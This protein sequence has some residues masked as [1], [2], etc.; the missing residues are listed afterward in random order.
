[1][2]KEFVYK[3]KKRLNSRQIRKEY[4]GRGISVASFVSLKN[5]ELD[6]Y[7]NF[8]HHCEIS[9]SKIGKRTSVGRYTK[10]Q[11]A[12]IGKYCS[13]SWD[14]TIGALSHPLNAIST[15][16]FSYRKQFGLCPKDYYLTHM[17]T[18]IG[19]DVWIGCGSIIMPGVVIGDGAVIGA[20]SVVLHDVKPY[21]VVAGIPAKHI[22][23]RFSEDVIKT[24]LD[25]KWWDFDDSIIIQKI[26]LFSPLIDITQDNEIIKELLNIKRQNEKQ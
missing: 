17:T 2:I 19:N 8:A 25:L 24:L 23:F 15:H 1:M 20:G 9:N 22:R 14:V 11:F 12:D 18:H 16:A 6:D 10:V 21:E 5:V 26:N 7:T 13:I 4:E 3:I